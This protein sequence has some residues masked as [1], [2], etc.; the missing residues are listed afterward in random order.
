M[1]EYDCSGEL[2]NVFCTLFFLLKLQCVG[3]REDIIF[4]ADLKSIL[5]LN[6]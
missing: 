2:N 4:F 3:K 1:S 6:F 5:K